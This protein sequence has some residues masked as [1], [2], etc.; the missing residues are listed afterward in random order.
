ML[1]VVH[2]DAQQE[3]IEAA[4]WY[5][6][7]AEARGAAKSNFLQWPNCVALFRVLSPAFSEAIEQLD[8]LIDLGKND[9]A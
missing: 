5:D 3:I 6:E 1:L 4:D 2:P 8:Y 7:R 9:N